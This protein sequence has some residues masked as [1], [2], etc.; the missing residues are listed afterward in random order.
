MPADRPCGRSAP[1][2]RQHLRGETSWYATKLI[3]S[4]GK[5]RLAWGWRQFRPV[6]QPAR[7]SLADRPDGAGPPDAR[8]FETSGGTVP[9]MLE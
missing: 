1:V 9:G 7:L 8:A 5:G 2:A 4:F 6:P 3:T